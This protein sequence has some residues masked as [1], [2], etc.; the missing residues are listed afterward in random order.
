MKYNIGDIV[1][2][3]AKLPDGVIDSDTDCRNEVG[4]IDSID[5]YG[6]GDDEAELYVLTGEY[7]TTEYWWSP[8]QIHKANEEEIRNKLKEMLIRG[9]R[10]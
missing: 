9:E 5:E 8:S 1:V 4:I 6:V 7:D 2:I 3:D 10:M